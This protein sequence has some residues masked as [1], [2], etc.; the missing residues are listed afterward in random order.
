MDHSEQKHGTSLLGVLFDLTMDFKSD[1]EPLFN[2]MRPV[3]RSMDKQREQVVGKF[4]P[5]MMVFVVYLMI[6][7][8]LPYIDLGVPRSLRGNLFYFLLTI[9]S[10]FFLVVIT[11]YYRTF[12]EMQRT[13]DQRFYSALSRYLGEDLM[14]M[15]E[16]PGFDDHTSSRLW[17]PSY[18]H[19]E[20][21]NLIQGNFRQ[22]AFTFTQV[23][24]DWHFLDPLKPDKKVFSGLVLTY[25]LPEKFGRWDM[26]A[27][28]GHAAFQ[29]L[30][31]ILGPVI[32]PDQTDLTERYQLISRLEE[33]MNESFLRTFFEFETTLKTS[34]LIRKHLTLVLT[35]QM[36]ILA[37]PVHD[38]FWEMINWRPYEHPD[39]LLHQLLPILGAAR[40]A[41]SIGPLK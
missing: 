28:K 18:S 25:Q 16:A 36:L 8:L 34:R 4:R 19:L 7:L 12:R 33:S 5:L 17:M 15:Q 32:H 35:D 21:S 39:F 2:K 14:Y 23:E 20:A 24:A 10:M 37:I 22:R 3:L 31:G 6:C 9:G 1:I 41:D 26:I 40:V 27:E 30:E 13:A 11:I 29:K 38:R